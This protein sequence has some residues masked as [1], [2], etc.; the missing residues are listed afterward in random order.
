MTE[1]ESR[2]CYGDGRRDRVRARHDHRAV[3]LPPRPGHRDGD[4]DQAVTVAATGTVT[5][6]GPRAGPG[7]A[8]AAIL[9]DSHGQ[10]TVTVLVAGP[11]GPRRRAAGIMAV[12]VQSESDSPPDDQPECQPGWHWPLSLTVPGPAAVAGGC[13]SRRPGAGLGP[14]PPGGVGAASAASGRGTQ[15]G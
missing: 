8:G 11:A 9:I 13:E 10:A 1:S 2:D 4:P 15:A 6:G 5:A 3:G 7:R 14:R 12:Q